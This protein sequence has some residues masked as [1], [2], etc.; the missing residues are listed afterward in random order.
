MTETDAKHEYGLPP[1]RVVD[2]NDAKIDDASTLRA[3]ASPVRM[4]ILGLLRVQGKAT[5]G[6][7]CEKVGIATGS[8]SYHLAQLEKAGLVER[9]EDPDGDGRKRW[10]RACHRAMAP[11]S[12]S[13]QKDGSSLADYLHAVS[14]TYRQIYDRFVDQKS[15]L[16]AEWV[17]AAMNQDRTVTLTLEQMV[18]MNAEFDALAQHWEQVS[19]GADASETHGESAPTVSGMRKVALIIQSFPWLP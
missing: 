5:V 3:L 10:W 6:E 4:R 19:R 17:D 15:D 14:L 8:V 9:M 12:I 2:S 13:K 7:I 11:T 1:S 18:E 16:P